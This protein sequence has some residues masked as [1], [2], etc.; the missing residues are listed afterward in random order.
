MPSDVK[1]VTGVASG[2]PCV[3][4]LCSAH[5]AIYHQLHPVA[6]FAGGDCVPAT[7]T[8]AV[9]LGC[10]LCC[11]PAGPVVHMEEEL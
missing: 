9:T 5:L 8:E 2:R 6:K 11:D 10:M 4:T 1:R 3:R 7:V